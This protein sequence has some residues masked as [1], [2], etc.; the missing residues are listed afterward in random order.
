MY[1]TWNVEAQA[2]SG[3]HSMYKVC[4]KRVYSKILSIGESIP[5][6][7]VETVIQS[8]TC[9]ATFYNIFLPHNCVPFNQ[10]LEFLGKLFYSI[11]CTYYGVRSMPVPQHFMCNTSVTRV[12]WWINDWIFFDWKSQFHV[13]LYQFWLLC[14]KLFCTILYT[15][16]GVCSM[17]V[18]QHV[19]CHASVTG[20]DL[21][22]YQIESYTANSE[23]CVVN[24]FDPY[25]IHIGL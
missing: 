16:Y 3:F 2:W 14:S 9:V 22:I 23:G 17:P 5:E 24:S 11:L 13:C 4:C 15:Y 7:V 18:P 6:T 12:N 20:V 19:M 10:Y 1:Y 25:S 21:F 8:E